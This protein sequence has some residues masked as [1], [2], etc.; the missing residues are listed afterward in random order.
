MAGLELVV[1]LCAAVLLGG[2]LAQRLG[3][4]APVILVIAGLLLSM[5]P[6]F[7]S[8]VLPPEAVLLLFLPALLYWE[9]L[10][11]SLREIRRFI[12][13]VVLTGTVLVVVTAAAVA[14]V[15]HALGVDWGTAW[16]I[17]AAVAPTDAT[18]TAALSGSMARRQIT[19]LRAESLINDGTALVVYGLA[20]GAVTGTAELGTWG[21][22]GLF[23]LSFIGGIGIGLLSGWTMFQ[24]R[25][26]LTDPLFANV[27]SLLTPFVTYLIAEQIHASGVL[28]V[29]TCGLY[30]SQVTPRAVQ[31]V[32][33]QQGVAFWTLSTFLL[34]GALFVLVGLQVP[35]S[36]RALDSTS[37]GQGLAVVAAVFVSILLVRFGFLVISAYLIRA[38]D[39]RPQ[40]RLL[41]ATNSARLVSTVAGLRGAVSLAVALAVPKSMPDG[42]GFPDRDLIVF[43][44][45][46]VVVASLILQGLALPRVIQ[47][48]QM[49]TD[50]SLRDELLMA[51]R[52]AIEAALAALPDLATDLD[53]PE[54]VAASLRNEYLEHL[55]ATRADQRGISD[56]PALVRID[57]HTQLRLAMIATKRATVVR[58]RDQRI[59]DDSAL[60][61]IQAQLDAEDVRLRPPPAVE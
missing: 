5:L 1:A 46:C 23:A 55:R 52:A 53:V 51:Q 48:A 41:R 33:R 25:R 40:Q 43:V 36:V 39:R 49:P 58:L 18:A 16:I 6:V 10:T 61:I 59:I 11:T 13:G 21:V 29:V 9:S 17:G 12:R 30:M 54:D 37:I 34:N 38:V 50:T 7:S 32:T 15:A 2:V 42:S 4:A 57:R 60:R 44:V 22:S 45:A 8:V 24:V 28:A 20:V 47:W 26:R 27:G 56:H 31:V 19:V 3:V 14:A 35:A